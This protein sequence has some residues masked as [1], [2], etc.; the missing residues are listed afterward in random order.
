MGRSIYKIQEEIEQ[1]ANSILKAVEKKYPKEIKE[2]RKE[3]YTKSFHLE[4]RNTWHYIRIHLFSNAIS[5]SMYDMITKDIERCEYAVVYAPHENRSAYFSIEMYQCMATAA[6]IR[7]RLKWVLKRID[8]YKVKK[9]E[10]A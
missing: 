6:E 1:T 2:I 3:K 7:D 9:E 5:I 4:Y 8:E 10:Y